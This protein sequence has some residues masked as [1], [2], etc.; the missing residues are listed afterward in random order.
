[1]TVVLMCVLTALVSPALAADPIVVPAD[2]IVQERVDRLA[3]PGKLVGVQDAL[4]RM[5]ALD[6]IF[7]PAIRE[8]DLPEEIVAVAFVE[9]RF[10]NIGA[11]PPSR[12]AGG[13]WQMIPSTAENYG[14]RV[15]AKMDERMV[16][17]RCTDAALD[18]LA[19]LHT[20]YD[21]WGLAFAAYNLGSA[22]V[23]AV[24][25]HEGT[26]DWVEL[27]RRGALPSYPADVMAAV[28]VVR[29]AR[30]STP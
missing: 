1:M 12:P 13:V 25:E 29:G 19:V 22:H 5:R 8:R 24:I 16:V 2:P 15:D 4:A 14:L 7:A 20:D 9:S 3:A 17:A 26:R 18:L 6:P 28:V 23:N 11:Q 10:Q 27:V 30:A 21:D